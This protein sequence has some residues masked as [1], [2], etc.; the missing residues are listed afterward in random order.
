MIMVKL[1]KPTR[2]PETTAEFVA[3][4]NIRSG[5]RNGNRRVSSQ[6]TR[7]HNGR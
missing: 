6:V 4:M 7:S 5:K 2:E 3:R 1:E